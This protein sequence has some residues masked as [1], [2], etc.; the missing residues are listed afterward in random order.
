[1]SPGYDKKNV[2]YF[3][4]FCQQCKQWQTTFLSHD[5]SFV[6]K[7]FHCTWMFRRTDEFQKTGLFAFEP[8]YICAWGALTFDAKTSRWICKKLAGKDKAVT[9]K[10]DAQF[11]RNL[12][13]TFCETL[14]WYGR[15][16]VDIS[17]NFFASH[18]HTFPLPREKFQAVVISRFCKHS[19]KE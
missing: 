5:R 8:W 16:V 3:L 18:R 13:P 15:T 12:V 9:W 4:T 7:L 1:M 6:A 11:Y 2:A 19:F 10:K 17:G 14:A